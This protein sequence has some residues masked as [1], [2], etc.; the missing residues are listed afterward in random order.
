MCECVRA[1]V[2]MIIISSYLSRLGS[3][4]HTCVCVCGMRFC[5]HM[6]VIV[7]VHALVFAC[8]SVLLLHVFAL[9]IFCIYFLFIKEAQVGLVTEDLGS[10]KI[11]TAKFIKR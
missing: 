1:C 4:V 5:F 3:C 7:L 8:Y 9:I 6:Q 2:C 10:L 11:D